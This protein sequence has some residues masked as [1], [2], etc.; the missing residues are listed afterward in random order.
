MDQ[1]PWLRAAEFRSYSF[2]KLGVGALLAGVVVVL[3]LQVPKLQMNYSLQDFYPKTHPLLVDEAR[4]KR[5]FP[6]LSESSPFLLRVDLKKGSFLERKNILWVD[7]LVEKLK[8]VPG[9]K[10][11][12]AISNLPLVLGENIGTLTTFQ[13]SPEISMERVLADNP[14]LKNQFLNS[15]KKSTLVMITPQISPSPKTLKT[16]SESLQ[17]LSQDLEKSS[18]VKVTVLG[19]PELQIQGGLLIGKQV[20]FLLSLAFVLF[21]SLFLVFYRNYRPLLF[22]LLGLSGAFLILFGSLGLLSIPISLLLLTLPILVGVTL[23]STFLHTL[24]HFYESKSS[25]QTLR[26]LFKPNLLATLTTALGFLCLATSPLPAVKSFAFITSMSIVLTWIYSQLVL[27]MG[28]SWSQPVARSFFSSSQSHWLQRTLKLSPWIFVLSVTILGAFGSG[29]SFLNFSSRLLNDLPQTHGLSQEFAKLESDFGG[30][31]PLQLSLHLAKEDQWRRFDFWTQLDRF[32]KRLRSEHPTVRM[33]SL[34]QMAPKSLRRTPS[35][36]AD[37][38]SLLEMTNPELLERHLDPSRQKV[39]ISLYV[40]DYSTPQLEKLKKDLQRQVYKLFPKTKVEIGGLLHHSHTITQEASKE[41]VY[42]FWQSLLVIG[43]LMALVLK[44]WRWALV[45]LLPNLIPPAVLVGVL[46]LTELPIKPGLALVFSIALGLAFNNTVYIL[47]RYYRSRDLP[48]TLRL[49]A[50]PCL[51]ESLIM[52]VGFSVF[53]FSPFPVL[54]WFGAL[55]VISVIAG[56]WGDLVFLP[57]LLKELDDALLGSP[58]S[59]R[60]VVKRVW[61][62]NWFSKAMLAFAAISFSAQP[63]S[64]ASPHE[65]TW[66]SHWPRARVQLTTHSK[67]PIN[68]DSQKP[69]SQKSYTL[70]LWSLSLNKK[71]YLKVFV[72]DPK[73]HKDMRILIHGSESGKKSGFT[74][75]LKVQGQWVY[76][77]SQKIV[78]RIQL[79]N[80]DQQKLLGSEFESE[81]LRLIQNPQK[82][83]SHKN[84]KLILNPKTKD[85]TDLE[86]WSQGK[87]IKTLSLR[88][89]SQRKDGSWYYAQIEVYNHLT[90]RSSQLKVLGFDESVK[91]SPSDF[92]PQRL[93]P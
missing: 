69:I 32:E 40:P 35:G 63:S 29:L 6:T 83:R 3:S 33:M 8:K 79:Q 46:A 84:L 89:L 71:Y 10:S 24:N 5:N 53:L 60:S 90:K 15:N 91:L 85:L 77:P 58:Q 9:V 27:W 25:H 16:I 61:P 75:N 48:G 45:S 59:S 80:Q 82:L 18:K 72:L 31:L 28:L 62:R 47:L 30:V 4:F 23:I 76:L 86:R 14:L 1:T 36:L 56:A 42:G 51:S 41:I 73:P 87:K 70:D 26:E 17:K 43:L 44:S 39:L 92:A 67:T 54:H 7:Q 93:N 21:L 13:R 52:A 81:D 49:E 66:S 57:S 2:T 34:H 11:V 65:K 88:N 22:A 50:A 55:M 37:H 12:Q 38:L 78:R 74:S 20:L 64:Q 19:L 68:S